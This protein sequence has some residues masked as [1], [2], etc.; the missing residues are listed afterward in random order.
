MSCGLNSLGHRV[1]RAHLLHLP[2]SSVFVRAC[3]CT[4][5]AMFRPLLPTLA[6]PPVWFASLRTSIYGVTPRGLFIV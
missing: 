6:P 3:L 4:S 1:P 5:N 2:S